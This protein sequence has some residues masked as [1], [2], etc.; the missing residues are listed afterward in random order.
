MEEF[1]V[2]I[3]GGSFAGLSVATQLTNHKVLIID[4][5]PIGKEIKSTCGTLL[6]LIKELNLEDT[7]SQVHN[8][9]IMH[10]P[11]KEF[12][13][14]IKENPF[15]VIDEEKFNKKLFERTNAKFIQGRYISHKENIVSTDKGNF[16]GKIL[17]DASG[18]RAV[19]T[20]KIDVHDNRNLFFGIE[21]IIPYKTEGLHYYFLPKVFS[22]GVFW[23]FPQG[24]T[25]RIGIGSYK[26]ELHLEEKLKEFIEKLGLKMENIH[27]GFG[28]N[29]LRKSVLNNIFIVGDAAGHCIPLTAE[30]IRPAIIFG[31]KCGEFIN[32]VLLG[33]RT[34]EEA[35]ISYDMLIRKKRKFYAIER[36]L[37]DFYTRLPLWILEPVLNTVIKDKIRKKILSHYINALDLEEKE[38]PSQ[39]FVKA[40]ILTEKA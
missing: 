9:F 35:L 19:L 29:K 25:S 4:E 11:T 28:S 1:D 27:G 2:I 23:I 14:D 33:K 15:C 10:T 34:L 40:E 5:K 16:K 38:L 36:F 22:S 39:D 20:Y 7:V 26:A 32:E 31:K 3:I 18:P 12:V 21:S 6:S 8:S 13:F 30:G 17:V 24:E 37:Q